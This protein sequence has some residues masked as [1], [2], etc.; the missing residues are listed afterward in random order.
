MRNSLLIAVSAPF[1]LA[2][3]A[4]AGPVYS[5]SAITQNGTQSVAQGQSQL[6]M[7]VSSFAAGVI[8]FR[9]DN[10]GPASFVIAQVYWD[11]TGGLL[12]GV[13]SIASGAGVAFAGGGTPTSLPNANA[14]NFTSSFR[15]S[16]DSPAPSNGVGPGETLDVRM[17]L[18]GGVTLAQVLAAL[19]TNA[20]RVGIHA[21]AFANGQSEAFV[22]TNIIPLPG[23]AAMGSAGLLGVA[24]RRRR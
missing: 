4:A 16:A 24:S 3:A 15:I 6:S 18:A 21:T 9:F 20:M 13:N 23:A 10:V 5:F 17:N 2:A 7:T 19:D 8:N 1:A 14:A 11:N 12:S 22:S